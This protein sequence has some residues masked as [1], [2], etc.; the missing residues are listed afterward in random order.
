MALL[1]AEMWFQILTE[2]NQSPQKAAAPFTGGNI[3]RRHRERVQLQ[4]QRDS[5]GSRGHG[6]C[7]HVQPPLGLRP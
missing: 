6:R 5:R 4:E 3:W 2:N 7:L 1:V